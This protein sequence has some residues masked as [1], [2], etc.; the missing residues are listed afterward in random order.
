METYSGEALT[1]ETSLTEQARLESQQRIEQY[2]S[3]FTDEHETGIKGAAYLLG[4]THLSLAI[5]IW[6]SGCFPDVDPRTIYSE[7]RKTSSYKPRIY[8]AN[9]EVEEGGLAFSASILEAINQ[10]GYIRTSSAQQISRIHGAPV[11]EVNSTIASLGLE[12]AVPAGLMPTSYKI[13]GKKN[14]ARYNLDQIAAIKE[15]LAEVN[16][17]RGYLSMTQILT[18][19]RKAARERDS[20]HVYRER[21]VRHHLREAEIVTITRRNPET[22]EDDLYMTEESAIELLNKMRAH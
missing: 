10:T 6:M 16:E 21:E 2:F 12:P 3:G 14:N 22:G 18:A 4:D 7:A 19:L 8:K 17:L 20:G 15:R 1:Q 5:G 9:F 13:D 11:F